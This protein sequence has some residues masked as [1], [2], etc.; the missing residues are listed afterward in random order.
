IAVEQPES[1]VQPRPIPPLPAEALS[2]PSMRQ[3]APDLLL[4]PN[5]DEAEAL[6]GV[7]NREVVHPTPEHRIDQ[8]YYPVNRLRPVSAKHLFEPAQ[9]RRPLFELG[10][11]M[12]PHRSAQTAEI[13]EVEPQETEALASFQVH[14]SALFIIDFH[15]QLGELLPES[16]GHGSHQPVMTFVGVDQDHQVVS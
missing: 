11:V 5:Y 8:A 7:P 10:R 3:M 9:E 15:L 1:V 14:S 12:R 13:A 4:H 16:F 6:A 2:F